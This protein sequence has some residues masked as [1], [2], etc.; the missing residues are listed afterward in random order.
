[1]TTDD[2]KTKEETEDKKKEEE[3]ED[4][5]EEQKEEEKEEKEEEGE[6]KEEEQKEEEKEEK[7][8]EGEDKEEEQKEEEKE[9]KEEEAKAVEED[10]RGKGREAKEQ[11]E[12][13]KGG[14]KDV[15]AD[16]TGLI[17]K[18]AE[19]SVIEDDSLEVISRLTKFIYSCT[20]EELGRIRTRAMLCQIYHHALHD[21]YE[22]RR[23]GKGKGL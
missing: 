20:S 7:E 8:E 3:G 13:E 22:S 21:R 18:L 19:V 12:E 16:K 1:M 17:N 6:D 14:E 10:I 2:G 15:G 11:M 5:E 23:G 9:E 4:K